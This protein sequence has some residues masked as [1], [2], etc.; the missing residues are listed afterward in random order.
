MEAEITTESYQDKVNA[1]NNTFEFYYPGQNKP[2]INRHSLRAATLLMHEGFERSKKYA[3]AVGLI[4]HIP[5]LQKG[6]VI[7]WLAKLPWAIIKEEHRTHGKVYDLV[8]DFIARDP[9]F[10]ELYRSLIDRDYNLAEEILSKYK[11]LLG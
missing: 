11:K 1:I 6:N 7:S 4:K 3:V 5:K 2:E 9:E 10:H 8:R